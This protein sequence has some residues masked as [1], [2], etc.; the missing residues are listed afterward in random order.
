VLVSCDVI[1]LRGELEVSELH[2][3]EDTFMMYGHED[4]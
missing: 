4:G 2:L 1:L 3:D